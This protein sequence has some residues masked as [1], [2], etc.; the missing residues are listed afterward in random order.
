MLKYSRRIQRHESSF[1]PVWSEIASHVKCYL[2]WSQMSKENRDTLWKNIMYL[3]EYLDLYCWV[4]DI[5]LYKS[6]KDRLDTVLNSRPKSGFCGCSWRGAEQFSLTLRHENWSLH[7]FGGIRGRDHSSVN[8]HP[9]DSPHVMTGCLGYKGSAPK[10]QF[11]IT[12]MC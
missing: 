2:S 3:V 10:P 12:K 1:Y 5:K 9:G 8:L 7:W 4:V 6:T 11:R